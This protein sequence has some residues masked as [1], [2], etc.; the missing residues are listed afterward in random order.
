MSDSLLEVLEDSRTRGLLGPGAL[1]VHVQQADGFSEGIESGA[2]V[3]D[4]GSG[5][6]VP[7]LAMLVGRE[8][9]SVVLVD[10][11]N[12]RIE[13]LDRALDRLELR[14]R[15]RTRWGRAEDLARTEDLRERFDAVVSRSFGPPAVTAE[16]ARGFLRTGG[17]LVVSEPPGAAGSEGSPRWDAAALELLG[18]RLEDP[19]EHE[20][21]GF[22]VL[23][24]I[25]PCPAAVPR[26]AGIPAKRP[27]F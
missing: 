21:F 12:R 24:A 6:G 19:Y 10:A 2:D 4:L 7:G 11:A 1:S 16:C 20:G 3:V 13:F 14:P 15:A 5:G 8:D 9:I 18:F 26:R 27:R 22:Q 17:R 25:G 23:T